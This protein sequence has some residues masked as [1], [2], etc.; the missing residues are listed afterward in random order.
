L[1]SVLSLYK[2]YRLC[3]KVARDNIA[4]K[5]AGKCRSDIEDLAF[6][7]RPARV[8]IGDVPFRDTL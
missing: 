2:K 4:I 7:N 8:T 5:R 3:L 1:T 6:W